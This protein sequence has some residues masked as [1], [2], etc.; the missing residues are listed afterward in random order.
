M[1][2]QKGLTKSTKKSL[3]LTGAVLSALISAYLIKKGNLTLGLLFF[4]ST[5]LNIMGFGEYGIMSYQ[6]IF[7]ASYLITSIGYY[8]IDSLIPSKYSGF[9]FFR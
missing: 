8:A 4:F 5:A 7:A 6:K 3:H 2:K 9:R 1:K